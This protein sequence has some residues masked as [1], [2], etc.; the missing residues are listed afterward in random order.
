[1][2]A[3]WVFIV[4]AVVSASEVACRQSPAVAVEWPASAG[5]APDSLSRMY[6]YYLGRSPRS[7]GGCGARHIAVGYDHLPGDLLHS[8]AT[9]NTTDAGVTRAGVGAA[10]TVALLA[11]NAVEASHAVDTITVAVTHPDGSRNQFT[12]ARADEPSPLQPLRYLEG[13]GMVCSLPI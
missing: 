8:S 5:I 9:E 11:W 6:A 12:F 10:T 13:L 7:L 3:T 2:K 1:M 4:A